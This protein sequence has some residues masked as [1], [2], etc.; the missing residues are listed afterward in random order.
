MVL[1]QIKKSSLLCGNYIGVFGEEMVVWCCC[2]GCC[3]VGCCGVRK[4]WAGEGRCGWGLFGTGCPIV[5]SSPAILNL[6]ARLLFVLQLETINY[7]VAQVF[8]LV[9]RFMLDVFCV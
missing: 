2:F 5:C 4:K 6:V 8:L 3:R 9:G 7:I 1:S